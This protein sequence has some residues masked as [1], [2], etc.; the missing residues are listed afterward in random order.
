MLVCVPEGIIKTFLSETI[1]QFA[2]LLRLLHVHHILLPVQYFYFIPCIPTLIFLILSW[3]L[4]ESP[5]WLMRRAEVQEA[6]TNLQ[7]VRGDDYD[8][9][10]EIDEIQ[11]V[12]NKESLARDRHNSRS[13]SRSVKM[14]IQDSRSFL[15][16]LGITCVLFVFQSTCGIDLLNNY[17]AIIFKKSSIKPEFLAIIFQVKPILNPDSFYL[18]QFSRLSSHW[19]TFSP[20]PSCPCWTARTST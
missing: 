6:R 4:P 1:L 9:T 12:I 5:V 19:A 8:I 3:R 18:S 15:F 2:F 11:D 17:T 16:P 20:C 13:R 10:P 7:C 14:R